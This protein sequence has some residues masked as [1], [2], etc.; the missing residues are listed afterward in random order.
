MKGVGF[1]NV[2]H[3]VSRI[4]GEA[5]L[6]AVLGM[7]SPTDRD[8]AAFGLAV[9]WY[10]VKCFAR[11]LR[12][13]DAVC[14]RGDLKLLPAVGAYEADQDFNRVYR[15]FLRTLSPNTFLAAQARL[16]KHFQDSGAWRWYPA[17]RGI[18]AILSGWEIDAALCPE[19]GGYLARVIEFTGGKDV[20]FEH[21]ECRAK[22]SVDC[23]F[24]LRWR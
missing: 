19:M 5:A 18:R 7:L 15:L 9:G 8:I 16:W 22:G 11:F 3:Y 1:A 17:T 10:E 24:M 21:P 2:R 6:E 13:V 23:V 20:S 12:A 14:G 4:H